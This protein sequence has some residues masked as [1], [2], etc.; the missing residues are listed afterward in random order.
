MKGKR[1]SGPRSPAASPE[2][3]SRLLDEEADAMADAIVRTLQPKPA[4]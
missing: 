4:S 1:S 2:A 3:G